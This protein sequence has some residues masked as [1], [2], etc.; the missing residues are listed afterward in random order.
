MG[1]AERRT[2][3]RASLR[4]EILDAARTLFVEEGYDAVSMRKVA[5]RIEYSPTTIYLHFKDKAELFTA[6]TEDMFGG[7]SRKLAAL[8]KKG[9]DPLDVLRDGL[10]IYAKFALQHK[11][12]Y[13][14]AFLLPDHPGAAF[15]GSVAEHAFNFLREAVTRCVESGAFRPVD[16]ETTAQ[17]LWAAVHGVVALII[18]KCTFP[19]V[20]TDRLIDETLDTMIR[21]LRA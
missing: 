2:R 6:I 7:L 13:T 19:F 11:E 21:G 9:G 17:S 3:H 10:R 12:H 20:K 1:I 15:E 14:V 16:I 4:E 8:F 5:Q 18:T